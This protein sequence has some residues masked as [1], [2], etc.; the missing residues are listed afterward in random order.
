MLRSYFIV[1]FRNLYKNRFSSFINFAGLSIGMISFV[2]IG[3]YVIHE[4]SY[5]SYH[6]NAKNIFR[7]VKR[8]DTGKGSV[9]N[10]ACGPAPLAPALIFEFP[11][12]VT[13]V[14]RFYNYWGL[15]YN[16][17]FEKKIFHETSLVFT[18]PS[19]FNIFDFEFLEGKG[20]TALQEPYSVVLSE[21]MA[22]KYFGNNEPIGKSL[23]VEDSYELQVTGIIKD[24]PTQSHFHFGF[25]V[26]F[27]TL[28]TL[29][30]KS[31]VNSWEDEFCYTYILLRHCS[32]INWHSLC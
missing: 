7:V 22:V 23:R 28:N 20:E 17:Q 12:M 21:S 24:L 1:A 8:I 26:S 19:V 16:V 32:K 18:D 31:A 11:D 5:D 6:Q 4:F 10:L 25:M 29:P 13:E 30:W 3:L 9:K 27:S 14:V 2:V 15:G